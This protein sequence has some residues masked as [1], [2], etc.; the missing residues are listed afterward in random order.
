M[1]LVASIMIT[2]STSKIFFIYIAN[3]L[4]IVKID[5]LLLFAI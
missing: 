4:K 3:N 5:I 2:P 1:F